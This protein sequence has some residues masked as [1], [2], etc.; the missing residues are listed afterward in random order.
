MCR[1]NEEDPHSQ[2]TMHLF[3]A[4]SNKK[5]KWTK[6]TT[7]NPKT[8]DLSVPPALWRLLDDNIKR[9]IIVL[10]KMHRDDMQRKPNE[11]TTEKI[12]TEK[13]Q[14]DAKP[15]T[16]SSSNKAG[17]NQPTKILTRKAQQ[18]TNVPPVLDIEINDSPDERFDFDFEAYTD[19]SK[20]HP[21]LANCIQKV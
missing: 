1:R 14:Y 9:T 15:Q 11:N 16:S 18:A 10:R 3:A 17:N 12:D 7:L 13:K 21:I 2:T 6:T 8:E 20:I 4:R 5:V 19:D